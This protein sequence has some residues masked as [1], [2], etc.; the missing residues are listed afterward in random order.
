MKISLYLQFMFI[1]NLQLMK[2]SIQTL[3]AKEI[4]TIKAAGTYKG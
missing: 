3:L 2:K 4:E 1:I